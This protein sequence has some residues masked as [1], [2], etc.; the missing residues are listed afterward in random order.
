MLG[1]PYSESWKRKRKGC[2]KE[3]LHKRKDL[4]LEW[5]RE[6]ERELHTLC[7]VK[8]TEWRKYRDHRFHTSLTPCKFANTKHCQQSSFN[9]M[10]LLHLYPKTNV[11]VSILRCIDVLIFQLSCRIS[12]LT[13]CIFTLDFCISMFINLYIARPTYH[14]IPIYQC[15][16][17]VVIKRRC[18]A[19]L[20]AQIEDV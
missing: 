13:Y 14:F 20:V 11:N 18:Y 10:H 15:G 8:P 7:Q 6:R 12:R 17:T 5:K 1:N 9:K 16:W 4:S 19:S 2:G 3:D